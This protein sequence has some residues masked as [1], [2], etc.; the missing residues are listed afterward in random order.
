[1]KSSDIAFVVFAV[2]V[3][4]AFVC[5]FFA[6][7]LAAAKNYNPKTAWHIGFWF[8]LIGFMYVMGL[9]DKSKK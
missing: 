3:V 7:E 5:A 1:M 8:G 2:L 4:Q 9:P 6:K